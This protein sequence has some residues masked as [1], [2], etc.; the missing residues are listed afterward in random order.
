M[1][2]ADWRMR[3]LLLASVPSVW[4]LPSG[5]FLVRCVPEFCELA[6]WLVGPC[7]GLGTS[8]VASLDSSGYRPETWPRPAT[9]CLRTV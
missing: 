7:K 9:E 4:V 3:R 5:P 2:P 8:G 6:G 1:D